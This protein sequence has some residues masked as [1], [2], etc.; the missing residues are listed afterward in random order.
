MFRYFSDLEGDNVPVNKIESC[1]FAN[2]WNYVVVTDK[3]FGVTL[4]NNV[5]QRSYR[6]AVDIDTESAGTILTNNLVTDVRRSPDQY[7]HHTL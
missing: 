1:A 2:G 6:S 3:S 7:V 4:H 5:M